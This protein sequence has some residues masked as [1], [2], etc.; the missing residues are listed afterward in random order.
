[1]KNIS[2]KL[3][4]VLAVVFLQSCETYLEEENPNALSSSTYW[5]NLDQSNKNLT[6]V[7]GAMLNPFI[8]SVGEESL[9][10]DFAFPGNRADV[11]TGNGLLLFYKQTIN[12]DNSVINSR[13][14]ALYRVIFRAN[15]VIDGL[16]GMTESLKNQDLWAEQMGQARF[17]RGLA[18]FY[19]HS[20]YN[21]GEIV[22]RDFVPATTEDFSKPLSTSEEVKEFFR[23]DLLYAYDNLPNSF[24]EK[25]RVTKGTAATIL[26][27]SF[28]YSASEE[29]IAADYQIAKTYFNDVITG[30]YGYQLVQDASIMFT[31][32]GDYNSES[33]LEINY[34]TNQQIEDDNGDVESF[35]TENARLSAPRAGGGA[36]PFNQWTPSAWLINAY[37]N[38]SLDVTDARNTVIDPITGLPRTRTVSLRSSA[39]I[40]MV[41]DEDVQYYKAYSAPVLQNFA[42]GG[43]YANFKKY[44]NHDITDNESN[45]GATNFK[46]GKNVI[47]NRLA[48]VYLMYAECLIMADNNVSSAIENYIN[49]V[50][51]RWGLTLLDPSASLVDATPYTQTS[52]MNHLMFVERPLELSTE[53]FSIRN[54]DLRR[55]G[56]AAQRFNDLSTL[57]F[58]VTDYN[59]YDPAVN[60]T[61]TGADCF[62]QFGI[63]PDPVADPQ[64]ERE[65]VDA[66]KFYTD[67]YFPLPTSETL[68]NSEVTG[69]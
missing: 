51:K 64:I 19:L 65:H 42:Q 53:G 14:D 11:R 46:S 6:S 67:G 4:V 28:L 36:N 5:Q 30:P 24:P 38:E 8:I 26:G 58:Y 3:I 21:K 13:W 63:S 56:V 12:E 32:A 35:F 2:I 29:G 40:A 15:Q 37:A 66:A 57:D 61:A 45:L 20:V 44:T 69:G 10:S 55:W 48:D 9:R 27:T 16:N 54:I 1:M 43:K 25:T 7:Y 39:M 60:G 17:F 31:A 68:N 22:I 34:S 49:P 33:I 41:N 18:H 47:L 59:Y 52:L 62:V 50:R 23:A